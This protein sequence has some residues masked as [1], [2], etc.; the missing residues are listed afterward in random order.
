[1]GNAV[2][3]VSSRGPHRP[4][5]SE[6]SRQRVFAKGRDATAA[7]K[8]SRWDRE[9]LKKRDGTLEEKSREEPEW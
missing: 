4:G 5:V 8:T 1:M 2:E 3:N 7:G 9:E 6:M